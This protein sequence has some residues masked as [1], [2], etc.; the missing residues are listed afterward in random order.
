MDKT[1]KA[2]LSLEEKFQAYETVRKSGATNMFDI[3]R[4]SELSGLTREEV[5]GIM[6]NYT[7]LKAQFGNKNSNK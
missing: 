5:V 1:I 3:K 4:V 7:A 6:D 2:L